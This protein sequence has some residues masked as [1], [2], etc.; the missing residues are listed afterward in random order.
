MDR[1]YVRVC[2]KLR[3]EAKK[4]LMPAEGSPWLGSSHH[5]RPPL[6]AG[7]DKMKSR[8]GTNRVP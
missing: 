4:F 1:V 6:R 7:V 8:G 2:V 5:V 3:I